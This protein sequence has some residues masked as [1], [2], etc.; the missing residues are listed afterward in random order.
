MPTRFSREAVVWLMGVVYG[1]AGKSRRAENSL[2][3][4]PKSSG[5]VIE[6]A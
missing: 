4:Q 5:Q 6:L 3:L 1:F 2:L